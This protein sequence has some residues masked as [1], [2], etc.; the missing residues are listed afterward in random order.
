[1]LRSTPR[2]LNIS[3]TPQVFHKASTS[4]GFDIHRESIFIAHIVTDDEG[5]LK[6]KQLEDFTDSKLYLEGIQAIG[7]AKEQ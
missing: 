4:F 1:M 3:S 7:K 6:I 2:L 5:S